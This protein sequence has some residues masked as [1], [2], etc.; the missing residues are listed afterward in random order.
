MIPVPGSHLRTIEEYP[1]TELD[2]R[3]QNPTLNDSLTNYNGMQSMVQCTGDQSDPEDD[4]AVT[5]DGNSPYINK[6]YFQEDS[7]SGKDALPANV[8]R[9]DPSIIK[10]WADDAEETER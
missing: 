10:M 5:E 4:C 8:I 9:D 3:E 1:N 6:R 2:Q 7:V